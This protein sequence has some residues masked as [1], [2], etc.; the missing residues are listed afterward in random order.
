[1]C[2]EKENIEILQVQNCQTYAEKLKGFRVNSKSRT[3]RT[4]VYLPLKTYSQ[5]TSR[6]KQPKM[7][8]RGIC[9]EDF[10]VFNNTK[11]SLKKK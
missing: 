5:D 1:M 11:H 3:K 7:R 6:L 8:D 2:E 4:M 10:A 9:K